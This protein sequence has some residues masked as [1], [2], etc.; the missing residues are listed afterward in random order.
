MS[1]LGRSFGQK[2]INIKTLSPS[3]GRSNLNIGISLRT[4]CRC[5]DRKPYP[6]A[7]RDAPHE[8][9]QS[10]RQ[11]RSASFLWPI[12]S[13][14]ER[15]LA[16]WKDVNPAGTGIAIVREFRLSFLCRRR[17]LWVRTPE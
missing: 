10:R 11:A 5:S 13:M 2:V 7:A 3:K 15:N 8:G 12:L 14:A 1:P 9:V 17:W 4:S 6:A 16:D